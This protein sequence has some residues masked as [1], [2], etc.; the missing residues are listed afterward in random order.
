MDPQSA[1]IHTSSEAGQ[2]VQMGP[3]LPRSTSACAAHEEV[4]GH[5]RSGAT[6]CPSSSVGKSS[7]T[8]DITRLLL[9]AESKSTK[10]SLQVAKATSSNSPTRN[11]GRI[12][13]RCCHRIRLQEY[14]TSETEKESTFILK[15]VQLFGLFATT[16]EI[17]ALALVMVEKE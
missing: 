7:G 11:F 13:S 10:A 17:S 8:A 15:L 6:A 4:C 5:D 14:Q 3:L 9:L 2:V 12:A 16:A 1:Q